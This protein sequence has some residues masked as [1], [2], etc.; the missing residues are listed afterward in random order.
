MSL[1]S[2]AV[3]EATRESYPPHYHVAVFP[4]PYARYVENLTSRRAETR[5][6]ASGVEEYR[7]R[8]GDSLWDIAQAHGIT[9]NRLK[10]ENDLAGSRIYAGQLLKVPGS[11]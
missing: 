6:A 7:V 1:E 3:L 4:N 8:R 2:S 10:E 11:R 5:V 9:V